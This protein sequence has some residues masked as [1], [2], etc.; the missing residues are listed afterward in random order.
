MGVRLSVS[1][2]E[3]GPTARDGAAAESADGA[4]AHGAAPASTGTPEDA[5]YEFDQDRILIG[6]GAGADV[7]L[8]HASVSTR[9][10]SIEQ[11]GGRYVV[12]DHGSTNG[13]RVQGVR[14]VP[15]RAKPLRE[16]DR[17]DVGA[18]VLAWKEGVPVGSSAT[19]ER[20]ASLARRLLRELLGPAHAGGARLVVANGPQEGLA[21]DIPTPPATL[22]I[23][24]GETCDLALR[25][26]DASR[27][28]VELVVDLEG[29]L[30][31][32][33]GS[34]NG[35]LVNDR[36]LPE[37]RLADRDELQVGATVVIFEDPLEAE[38]RA[39]EQGPD[40]P[41]PEPP[42]PE[43]A[44]VATGGPASETRPLEPEPADD[45]DAPTGAPEPGAPAARAPASPDP[46]GM[47][48]PR[49][50]SAELLVYA[51]AAAVF[52]ASIAGLVMLL[53]AA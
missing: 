24:R 22:L 30:A 35:L 36:R 42:P 49:L 27:E 7:R 6:R 4:E 20:T 3:R 21:L 43:P 15:E 14:L 10:A 17:I 29:V 16:G 34:K 52:A 12:I 2:R 46:S 5:R 50:A 38:L 53:R 1:P 47:E 32:D 8:P 31:R 25:D 41:V 48:R 28:H 40:E 33:L 39:A 45:P 51:L 18:F 26:A 9:H 23:G 37:K 11:R 13:T 19:G 44:S